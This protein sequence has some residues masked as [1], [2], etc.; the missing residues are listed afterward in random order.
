VLARILKELL[1]LRP[2]ILNREETNRL[3]KVEVLKKAASH[4]KIARPSI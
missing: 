4:T 1:N 3:W 2:S